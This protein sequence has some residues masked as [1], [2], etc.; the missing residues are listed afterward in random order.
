MSADVEPLRRALAAFPAEGWNAGLDFADFDDDAIEA[1]FAALL[2]EH[3]RF[4]VDWQDGEIRAGLLVYGEHDVFNAHWHTLVEGSGDP[5][6][7][8]LASEQVGNRAAAARFLRQSLFG[9]RPTG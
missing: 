3:G 5:P 2:A 7:V 1:A 8:E 9:A 4:P 6:M